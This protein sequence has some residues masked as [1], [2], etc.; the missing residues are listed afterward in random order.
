M[1]TTGTLNEL[2]NH[3]RKLME[4]LNIDPLSGTIS[5][6][7]IPSK[8][9]M[10]AAIGITVESAEILEAMDKANRAWK[11]NKDPV[12]SQVKEE[13]ADVL[14]FVLELCVLLR[15]TGDDLEYLYL[16]KYKK[17]LIRLLNAT[18]TSSGIDTRL[19]ALMDEHFGYLET[20]KIVK[21]AM[22]KKKEKI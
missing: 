22:E 16:T 17:N 3:Q 15:L 5:V 11:T 20:E 21:E 13:L 18:I 6:N 14:F 7:E 19:V 4:V 10:G 1:T 2:T 9:E 12:S 8:T